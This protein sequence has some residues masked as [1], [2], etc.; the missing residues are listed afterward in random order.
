L[1]LTLII[2]LIPDVAKAK[3]VAC[4]GDSITYGG[5]IP[6]R[7]DNSYPAQLARM[8][9]QFDNEWETQNFGHRGAT[10]LRNKSDSYVKKN[11]YNNALA[12]DP[13]VVIIMLGTNDSARASISEIEQRFIPD[14][15]A[16]IDAFAQL[17]SQPRIF[18]CYPP[19]IF[20]GNHG[21]DNT[22]RNVIIPLIEQL[23]TYRTVEVIDMYTPLEESGHLFPD[24]LHPNAEGAGMIAEIVASVILG[25]RLSPDLNGNGKVD[26]EDLI[27]L[28][29]HWGQDEP[30][31]DIVFDGII[32]T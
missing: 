32:D 11:A 29:E 23:P 5:G 26:I 12:S 13:D 7:N 25:S 15:L 14:Y 4:V 17:P 10:L 6:N 9:Q 31:V 1:V 3:L 21:N 22:I 16:L 8:L 2:G 20:G 18:V 19:P 30:S 24:Q 27:M 28:I